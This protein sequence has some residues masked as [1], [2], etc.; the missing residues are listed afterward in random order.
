MR[1]LT[2][3][4]PILSGIVAGILAY[5]LSEFV[6]HRATQGEVDMFLGF[7][8]DGSAYSLRPPRSELG[9]REVG[10]DVDGENGVDLWSVEGRKG[11]FG[12]FLYQLKSKEKWGRESMASVT[13]GPFEDKRIIAIYDDDNNDVPDRVAVVLGGVGE[14]Y[15]YCTYTDFDSNGWIDW[16]KCERDDG[17]DMSLIV[18]DFA[19]LP[20]D[21]LDL[22]ERLFEVQTSETDSEIMQLMDAKWVSTQNRDDPSR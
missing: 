5:A 3:T 10:K 20:A 16:I 19:F 13:L 7:D 14:E 1:L 2:K 18:R 8:R 9:L 21:V 15:D 12:E 11:E 4:T 22:K 17:T 6:F